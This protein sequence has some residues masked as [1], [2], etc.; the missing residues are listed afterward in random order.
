MRLPMKIRSIWFGIICTAVVMQIGVFGGFADLTIFFNI[1]ALA[2]VFGGTVAIALISYSFV[3]LKEVTDFLIF[4]FFLKKDSFKNKVIID[5]FKAIK[6]FDDKEFD[7]KTDG[8]SNQFA[9]DGLAM[10][11]NAN[12]SVDDVSES[13]TSRRLFFKK[14]HTTHAKILLNLSKYP[15]ALGLLG[16]STGMIQ[17]MMNLGS[18]GPD[19][20]GQAMAV[21]LTATFW[22][23]GV[24]NFVFLPLSDYAYQLVDDDQS[25]RSIVVDVL[26]AKKAG[27]EFEGI[28]T[29]NLFKLSIS[30]SRMIQEEITIF[31]NDVAHKKQV[32][33][34]NQEN[35]TDESMVDESK[36]AS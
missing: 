17:M 15:P 3:Q 34:D 20:I 10:L 31:L 35:M 4:G 25:L 11:N 24:A 30:D 13:L 23:I 8:A 6:K 22:G 19:S 18:G 16:A 1:H 12:L 27:E 21:A 36:N 14:S 2:L 32:A 9:K 5:L 7:L 28:L 33:T 26:V 29:K